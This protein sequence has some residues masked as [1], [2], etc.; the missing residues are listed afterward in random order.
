MVG[1]GFTLNILNYLPTHTWE[2]M[3]GIAHLNMPEDC[4]WMITFLTFPRKYW[5]FML[6]WIWKWEFLDISDSKER[7]G[8]VQTRTRLRLASGC[9]VAFIVPNNWSVAQLPPKKTPTAITAPGRRPRLPDSQHLRTDQSVQ[10]LKHQLL[11]RLSQ[12]FRPE[13][14]YVLV[15]GKFDQIRSIANYYFEESFIEW[16]SESLDQ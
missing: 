9:P 3:T 16:G 14:V 2:L 4:H 15:V 6:L 12:N 8:G 1:R 7:Y 11:S 13:I 10:A 5:F